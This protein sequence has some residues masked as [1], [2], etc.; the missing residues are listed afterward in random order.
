MLMRALLRIGHFG[1]GN[2]PMKLA[3][4]TLRLKTWLKNT[5]R[6]VAFRKFSRDNLSL[7]A[8]SHPEFKAKGF[9]VYTVLM[10]LAH[11]WP[12]D[13]QGVDAEYTLLYTANSFM[14]ILALADGFLSYEQAMHVAV[15]GEAFLKVWIGQAHAHPDIY[16]VRP[17]LHVLHHCILEGSERPSRRNVRLDATWMDED[18]MK[19]VSRIIRQTHRCTSPLTTLQRY[20]LLLKDELQILV[21]ET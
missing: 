4:A 21:D 3:K 12:M 8:G 19:K 7:K 16:R 11:I 15:V 14:G 2:V 18:F 13:V 10:W 6:S 9:D 20:L 17:K 1:L 5:K